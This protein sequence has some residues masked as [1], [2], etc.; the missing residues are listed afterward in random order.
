M[1]VDEWLATLTRAELLVFLARSRDNEGS[2][3][4]ALND[5][6]PPD[7]HQAYVSLVR[8]GVI[9]V[10]HLTPAAE[11]LLPAALELWEARKALEEKPKGFCLST[12]VRFVRR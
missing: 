4:A 10:T 5:L 2:W 12:E 6:A 9:G 3:G 1:S 11:K 7:Y 8:R